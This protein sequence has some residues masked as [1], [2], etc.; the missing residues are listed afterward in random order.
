M[1]LKQVG[2]VQKCWTV[3]CDKEST[4]GVVHEGAKVFVFN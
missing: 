2:V 4:G 1:F 3:K